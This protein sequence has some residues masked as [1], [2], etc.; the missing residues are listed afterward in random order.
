[1]PLF[2]EQFAHDFLQQRY[3]DLSAALIAPTSD[4]LMLHAQQGSHPIGIEKA[5]VQQLPGPARKQFIAACDAGFI[6]DA[7]ITGGREGFQFI[8]QWLNEALH[9][10]H[11]QHV[12]EQLLATEQP[13]HI[14]D[15]V[16]GE[17]YVYLDIRSADEA[18]CDAAEKLGLLERQPT[19]YR[20]AQTDAGIELHDAVQA[21]MDA[22]SQIS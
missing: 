5:F 10:A 14:A 4:W 8:P 2:T 3:P 12:T 15:Y 21:M 9:A 19:L 17:T 7:P 13:W 22:G 6:K 11:R 16:A 18:L 1:M 20:P